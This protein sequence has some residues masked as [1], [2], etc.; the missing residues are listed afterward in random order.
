MRSFE[1]GETVVRRD[2]Y[3]GRVWSGQALRVIAD[4]GTAL[5][6]ACCPGAE[7]LRPSPYARTRNDG[8]P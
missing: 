2:V 1:T 3:R 8:E 4:T 7:A 5:V 6:T